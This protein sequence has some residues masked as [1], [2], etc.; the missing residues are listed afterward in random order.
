MVKA[1]DLAHLANHLAKIARYF[2]T[3]SLG[4]RFEDSGKFIW[5]YSGIIVSKSSVI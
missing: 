2:K 4:F 3:Q 1:S 5:H